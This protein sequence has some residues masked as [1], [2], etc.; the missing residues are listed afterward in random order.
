MSIVYCC[1]GFTV[2]YR[3]KLSPWFTLVADAYPLIWPCASSATFGPSCH[4][5]EPGCWFSTTI[6][7][8][9]ANAG[10]CCCTVIVPRMSSPDNAVTAIFF[11]SRPCLRRQRRL[12][13]LRRVHVQRQQGQAD[14]DLGRRGQARVR[15]VG[16][17]E[18]L[19]RGWLPGHCDRL[20]ARVR[21]RDGVVAAGVG[22][23]RSGARRE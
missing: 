15:R 2:T 19:A 4:A 16:D 17:R 7:L 8:G 20:G 5:V 10:D 6:G 14:G 3:V 23:I 18:R 21:G 13:D 22:E 11:I 9:A 12:H 1:A